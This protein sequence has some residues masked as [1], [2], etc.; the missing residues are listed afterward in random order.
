MDWTAIVSGLVGAI[1]GGGIAGWFTLRGVGKAGEQARLLA[2]DEAQRRSADK[3]ADRRHAWAM[4]GLAETR[5]VLIAHLSW[6][7][8]RVLT[9]PGSPLDPL[10]I[11]QKTRSNIHLVGDV[12][13]I[14][15]YTEVITDLS[16][17]M[18][19]TLGE[20][21]RLKLAPRRLEDLDLPMLERTSAVRARL[22]KALDEQ[23]LRVIAGEPVKYLTREELATLA[24]PT[25]I[26]DALRERQ[27][28]PSVLVGP[29]GP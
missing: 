20:A 17:R 16:D 26:L 10:D 27:G 11:N 5:E 9:D 25:A 19:M 6:L 29:P 7:E 21:A 8:R 15:A 12:D 4:T 2:T 22:L 24:A 28:K 13:V 14:R 3:L 1:I 23:E 18:P